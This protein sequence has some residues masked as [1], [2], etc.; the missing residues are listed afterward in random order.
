MTFMA[1]TTSSA[2]SP[3]AAAQAAAVGEVLDAFG[4]L[5]VA[6]RRLRGRDARHTGEL[7]FAQA[8]VLAALDDDDG[9]P[10][11][12]LAEK[13]GMTPASVTCMLDAL[14]HQG[15]VTRVRSERD[16]RIMLTHVTERGRLLR[17][18]KRT[19]ARRAFEDA[20]ARLNPN[21]LAATPRVL[22]LLAAVME[23]M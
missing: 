18:Q 1:E 5:L 13:A 7:S 14:E 19:A 12:K 2:P 22:R 11:S 16:R 10:A 20:L 17:D 3:T 15:L 23:A 4:E 21:E 8:R 9:C 6:Q